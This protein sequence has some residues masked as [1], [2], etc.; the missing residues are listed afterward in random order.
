[1]IQK[2]VKKPIE[3]EFI[4]WDGKAETAEKIK[5]FVKP[6]MAKPAFDG[7]SGIIIETLGGD[8]TAKLN[9][10]II[11]GIQGECYPC[12]PGI[13]KKTYDILIK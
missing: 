2:A 1:M 7:K 3:I 4:V 10:L 6:R 5:E 8:H 13:F 11:K 9:D 12:K